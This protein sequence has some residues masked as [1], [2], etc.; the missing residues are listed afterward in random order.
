MFLHSRRRRGSAAALGMVAVAMAA[1]GCSGSAGGS[2]NTGGG[3]DAETLIAYTGQAG[4][5]QSN[6]NPYS[7]SL[8]GGPGTIFE[9]LFF[10]NQVQVVDPV[11][12]LGTDY[13]WNKD[14]TVLTIAT[15]EG[16]T[17]SDGE[18]FSANDVAFT[19]DMVAKNKAI[20]TVGYVG[21]AEATDDT[22]VVVTFPEPAFMDGPQVLGKM[23]IVP[24][25]IWS[26]IAD[27]ATDAVPEPIG[28]GPYT[29]ADFKPQAYT[30]TANPEYWDGEPALKNVRYLALS[31]NQSGADAL[32]AGQIDWQT[33]PV[34]DIANVE[35][36]YPGYKA[37]TVP[38][39]QMA[40]FTC[41]NTDLG[42]TGPQTDAAVRKAIYYAMDRTQLNALAFEKTASDMSPGLALMPRDEAY[43]SDGLKEKVAPANPEPDSAQALLE[44]AGWAKG[45]DG[46]YAKDG[47]RLAL[48]V[49]VVTGWTDYITAVDTMSQQLKAVGIKISAQQ[50][51]W[52][53]W[54]DARGQGQ[55]ELLIDSL[56]G[57]PAADPY[58]LYTYFLASENSAEVGKTAYP[59]YARFSDPEVD[60]ALAALK[61]IDPKDAQARQEHFDVI[62]TRVEENMPYIPIMTG[63][64][65]S[66]FNTAKFEGW[67]SKKDLYAFPAIWSR[68]DDVQIFVNL[69]P[70]GK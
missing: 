33:G 31:G 39:N 54:T 32:A 9:S 45:S 20:N 48:T 40:L 38:L 35:E 43:S 68:P 25:H 29:L 13:S 10:F 21:D 64:T 37:I 7:P 70:V 11:P 63:G 19:L 27:P 4:D 18:P 22:H 5:Y 55:F 60:S 61:S 28:T 59:N 53:E 56:N 47:K 66:E 8:I 30:L 44:G 6:F 41:S 2:G 57:G 16:V 17:W 23:F 69:K 62:Q 36:N 52:N 1:A 24:E 34:P 26:S 51:S 15:R 58:Y 46:I 67:P 65:T 14:G 49:K 12:L 42:C 3:A 50:V